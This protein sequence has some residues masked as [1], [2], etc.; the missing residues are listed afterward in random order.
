MEYENKRVIKMSPKTNIF[1][2][3]THTSLEVSED[4][5]PLL[6]LHHVVKLLLVFQA[7]PLSGLNPTFQIVTRP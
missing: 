7:Q 3:D 2:L 5:H 4:I 1:G 6:L